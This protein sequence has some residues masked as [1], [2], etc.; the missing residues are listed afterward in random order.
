M[1]EER[2]QVVPGGEGLI[3]DLPGCNAFIV[4]DEPDPD[5]IDEIRDK[6]AWVHE[7][8]P[9]AMQFNSERSNDMQDAMAQMDSAIAEIE[10]A[11]SSLEEFCIKISGDDIRNAVVR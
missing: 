8:L 7:N 10:M 6:I 5:R 3:R 4:V 2:D 11:E 1:V 9:E